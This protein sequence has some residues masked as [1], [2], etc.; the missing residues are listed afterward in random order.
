MLVAASSRLTAQNI[1]FSAV[2]R[3]AIMR[4][5]DFHDGHYAA[6]RDAPRRRALGR[7]DDGAHHLRLRAVARTRSSAASAA[8]DGPPRLGTDFQVESYLDHQAED[9][10][11]TAST[12][13]TY[14]YL[15]RVMDYFD[16]FAD[17]ERPPCAAA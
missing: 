9:R 2:A 4:D 5:P 11:S 6:A 10:S 7:P 3:T 13:C 1:A 17:P 14:L 8:D 15:T 12:R 16:P